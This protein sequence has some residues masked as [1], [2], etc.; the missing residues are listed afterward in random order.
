MENLSVLP[1]TVNSGDSGAELKASRYRDDN[2]ASS[3]FEDVLSEE[4]QQRDASVSSEKTSKNQ[5]DTDDVEQVEARVQAEQNTDSESGQSL[6]GAVG[7][8]TESSVEQAAVAIDDNMNQQVGQAGG[9][10][11]PVAATIVIDNMDGK[12]EKIEPGNNNRRTTTAFNIQAQTDQR[13]N[14]PAKIAGSTIAGQLPADTTVDKA[15][16]ADLMKAMPGNKLQ[17][18]I[19]MAEGR[20]NPASVVQ[21]ISVAS[22]FQQVPVATGSA[23]MHLNTPGLSADASLNTSSQAILH[24][25]IQSPVHS[26][27]WAQGVGEKV[28]I[29]MANQM[30]RAE[31]K[32]NPANLGPM[33][34]HLSLKDDKASINFVS[35]HLPVRDALD[36]AMPRLRE[37]LEQQGLNLVNVDVSQHSFG[38]QAESDHSDTESQT[39]TEPLS[40]TEEQETTT[41]MTQ[42]IR[43]IDVPD[44][45]SIF[46]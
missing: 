15:V 22:Q 40:I 45:L 20:L 17:V 6:A 31:I 19:P 1:R 12:A 38:Q 36:Q 21:Q 7:L 4:V 2:G 23:G 32:L 37:M 41:D 16:G 13:Q 34:I 46:A 11:L 28:S 30:Q 3:G 14:A 24:S 27:A 29:M 42:N 39:I 25:S 10:N 43:Q 5:T 33:E 44:G 9:N 26:S 8:L 35:Q 18:H